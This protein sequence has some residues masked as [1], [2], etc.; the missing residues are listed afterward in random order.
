MCFYEQFRFT[1]GDFKWGSFRLH[2]NKEYRMGETCGMKLVHSTMMQPTKCK[3]CEKADTKLRKREAEAERVRRWQEEGTNPASIEKSMDTIRQL[4]H[5]ILAIYS[6]ISSRRM[7]LASH[8]QRQQQRCAREAYAGAQAVAGSDYRYPQQASSAPEEPKPSAARTIPVK[9]KSSS[10]RKVLAVKRRL[11]LPVTFLD[12]QS[13]PTIMASPDTGSSINAISV[14]LAVRLGLFIELGESQLSMKVQATNGNWMSSCGY[15]KTTCSTDDSEANSYLSII[16]V[17]RRLTRPGLLFGREFLEKSKASARKL[18]R[19]MFRSSPIPCVRSIGTPSSLLSC[20]LNGKSV[21]AFPDSGSEVD[22][23]SRD[24]A[25]KYFTIEPAL[26][27]KMVQYVDGSIEKIL[28]IV[29]A[30]VIVGAEP[31]YYETFEDE[32]A[33]V[34]ESKDVQIHLGH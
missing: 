29:H 7:A 5:E 12:L 15:I 4:D 17:F 26:N 22:L 32:T 34:S 1:C 14:K 18:L 9:P 27:D 20:S 28:G 24:Y 8:G 23:M 10:A 2:C 31:P 19:E 3:Y 21:G 33:S 11:G 6:E 13:S 30:E 25:A 16:Y